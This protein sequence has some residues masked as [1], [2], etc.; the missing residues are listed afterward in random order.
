MG[1]KILLADDSI[2]IQKV[3][4]LTFSDEDFD[5]VTVGNGRLAIER[6]QEVRPDVVL[7]DI[8]MPEKDG[9]EVCDFIK[10]TPGL[11]HVPVLLLTGAFE[12][13]DQERAARVGC[14][15]YLAKPFEPQTLIAKVKDLLAQ[16]GARRPTPRPAAPAATAATATPVAIPPAPVPAAVAPAFTPTPQTSPGFL[17]PQRPA[18]PAPAAPPG[19]APWMPPAA[20]APAVVAPPAPVPAPPVAARGSEYE[21]FYPTPE[22]LEP[23]TASPEFE[24]VFAPSDFEPVEAYTQEFEPVDPEVAPAAVGPDIDPSGV[25]VAEPSVAPGLAWVPA[26][27]EPEAEAPPTF[28]PEDPLFTP[29]SSAAAVLPAP[30][31][32]AWASEPFDIGPEPALKPVDE[33]PTGPHAFTASDD[34]TAE[35]PAVAWQE[36][37]FEPEPETAPAPE[38]PLAVVA[39]QA[40]P[41]ELV[42][43]RPTSPWTAPVAAGAHDV[44]E[45][46]VE[47]LPSFEEAFDEPDLPAPIEPAAAA[48]VTSTYEAYDPGAFDPSA[49]EPAPEPQPSDEPPSADP[50]PTAVPAWPVAEA[51]PVAFEASAFEP[52]DYASPAV[53]EGAADAAPSEPVIGAE[54]EPTAFEAVDLEPTLEPV[55]ADAAAAASFESEAF[56]AEPAVGS[57]APSEPVLEELAEFE[58][59]PLDVPGWETPETAVAMPASTP[60]MAPA[61]LEE[62]GLDEPAP[63]LEALEDEAEAAEQQTWEVTEDTLPGRLTAP[64]FDD[65]PAAPSAPETPLEAAGADAPLLDELEELTTNDAPVLA[66]LDEEPEA[67]RAG[68]TL[69]LSS[70]EV[71]AAFAVAAGASAG[72]AGYGAPAP[73]PVSTPPPSSPPAS[74]PERAPA[75]P[76]ALKPTPADEELSFEDMSAALPAPSATPARASEAAA[77]AVP[78]EM[79]EQIARR[80]VAQLSEKVLREIAWEVVPELAEALIKKEIAR[81]RAEMDALP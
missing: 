49:F 4:E 38:L 51:A 30:V 54:F 63:L 59:T 15:G 70:A 28:I 53:A 47:E 60:E 3:I 26:E 41:V 78:V 58:P 20:A 81:I 44:S 39:P 17:P 52:A 13:F 7:C 65:V 75:A 32:P 62:A 23:L 50:M 61:A 72:A 57:A 27:P 56:E 21:A 19:V 31:P 68:R 79:V 43:D 42:P 66:S 36:P 22:E 77:V 34:A 55:A 18:A 8:I 48:T 10:K 9:Y 16:A 37:V 25:S 35:T 12:P 11:A 76:V 73:A 29:T 71:A 2:T 14:D 24:P 74:T 1:K 33:A 80:V 69:P 45:P 67:A 46:P 5:V 40:E 6:V 64:T